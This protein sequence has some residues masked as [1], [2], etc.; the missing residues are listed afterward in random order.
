MTTCDLAE[1]TPSGEWYRVGR[2]PDPWAWPD[3]SFVQADGTF[4][5]RW[6]DPDS[7]YRLIYASS[8]RVGAFLETMAWAR[9]DPAVDLDIASIVDD[10]GPDTSHEM[11][12]IDRSWFEKRRLG[13][14]QAS[15]VFVAIGHSITLSRLRGA[16]AE[17]MRRSGIDQLDGSAIRRTAP[18]SLT[19]RISRLI[20]AC[21]SADESAPAYDGIQYLS[22][23]GDDLECWTLFEGRGRLGA[24]ESLAIELDDPDLIEAADLLR[25]VLAP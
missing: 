17:D 24:M 1:V 18:R 23:H 25:V 6:D 13:R 21:R 12:V 7:T 15:G 9:P 22:K 10:A 11:G 4:G 8:R 3:W 5:G 14:A 16:V 19:Q 2:A 20:F